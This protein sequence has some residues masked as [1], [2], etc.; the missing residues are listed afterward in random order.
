MPPN[1]NIIEEAP[2]KSRVWAS[3]AKYRYP[4]YGLLGLALIMALWFILTLFDPNTLAN[5]RRGFSTFMDQTF[6]P[7]NWRAGAYAYSYQDRAMIVKDL[8]IADPNLA[9]G[10]R[11]QLVCQVAELTVSHL[12]WAKNIKALWEKPAPSSA[13]LTLASV[14]VAKGVKFLAS[15]SFGRLHGEINRLEIHNP[16]AIGG[17]SQ[18]GSNS[19][20]SLGAFLAGFRP[21]RIRLEK[22]RANGQGPASGFSY[23]FSLPSWSLVKPKMGPRGLICGPGSLLAGVSFGLSAAGYA[24]TGRVDEIAHEGALA[25]GLIDKLAILNLTVWLDKASGL[26]NL[27]RVGKKNLPEPLL[28]LALPDW[29]SQYLDFQPLA[30]KIADYLFSP[31]ALNPENRKIRLGLQLL[32]F[33]TPDD[34]LLGGISVFESRFRRLSLKIGAFSYQV[35]QGEL[36]IT[37]GQDPYALTT[38]LIDSWVSLGEPSEASPFGGSPFYREIYQKAA[39]LN[40]ISQRFNLSGRASLEPKDETY[41]VAATLEALDLFS[42]TLNLK[43]GGLPASLTRSLAKAPLGDLFSDLSLAPGLKDVSLREAQAR[44]RDHGLTA[45]LVNYYG[46]KE[47]DNTALSLKDPSPLAPQESLIFGLA[48]AATLELEKYLSDLTGLTDLIAAFIR[49]PGVLTFRAEPSPPISYQGYLAARTLGDLLDSAR[50]S[51][52]LD[53]QEPLVFKWK[54]PWNPDAGLIEDPLDWREFND[55]TPS[56]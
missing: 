4:A 13:P 11:G 14:M 50:L 24:V 2:L 49:A 12:T 1:P 35:N 7:N 23:I 39:A 37:A 44:F 40:L 18:G 56:H 22:L 54:K 36:A 8:W 41:Q 38:R 27:D 9:L 25:L 34:L 45:R 19:S 33:I 48:L 52:T 47:K 51:L 15:G 55:Q 3:L 6:G 21:E 26:A 29:T 5:S 43:L 20:G 53:G 30:T 10:G 42:L 32:S 28:E 46:S 17:L 31:K 16:S